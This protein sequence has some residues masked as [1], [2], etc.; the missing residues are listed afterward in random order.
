MVDNKIE[1]GENQ[2]RQLPF[3]QRL[4]ERKEEFDPL[5]AYS[6]TLD[7]APSMHQLWADRALSFG[8]WIVSLP[9]ELRSKNVPDL[10]K[11]DSAPKVL[12]PCRHGPL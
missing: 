2:H 6:H 12:R 4:R 3:Y 9:L 8:I 11:Q 1:I 5:K 7:R 10:H